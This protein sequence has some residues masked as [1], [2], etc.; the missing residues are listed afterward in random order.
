MNKV[1]LIGRLVRDTELTYTQNNTPVAAFTLAVDRRKRDAGAD[2]IRCKA[3]GKTAETLNKY[4]EKGDPLAI[5]GRIETGSYE[6]DGQTVYKTEV[7]VEEFDFISTRRKEEQVRES[8]YSK[9]T[10]DETYD[11]PF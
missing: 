5:V 7:V 9:P 6:R 4:V 8:A 10:F 3:W 11:L 1:Q 2:F